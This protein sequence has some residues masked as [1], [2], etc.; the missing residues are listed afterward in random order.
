MSD[1]DPVLA[2]RT[3]EHVVEKYSGEL[4]ELRRD[5]HAHPELSWAEERTT[6]VV[7]DRLSEAGVRVNR[8]EGTGLVAEVGDRIRPNAREP[9]ARHAQGSR[10]RAV[11][12]VRHARR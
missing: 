2:S 4:I 11:G 8:L 1:I 3:I 12:E 7:A 10:V 9:W 5:L 6:R